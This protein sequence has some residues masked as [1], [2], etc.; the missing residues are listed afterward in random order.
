MS[1]KTKLANCKLKKVMDKFEHHKIVIDKL[2][3]DI[4]WI[5]EILNPEDTGIKYLIIRLADGL[6]NKAIVKYSIN[7]DEGTIFLADLDNA[8]MINRGIGTMVLGYL[9]LRAAEFGIS[10]IYGYLAPADMDHR[11][12]LEWFYQKNGYTIIGTS[13]TKEFAKS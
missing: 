9:D 1:L 10:K 5:E 4:L 11:P 3:F 12:R 2:G 6:G 7:I 8:K 13:V